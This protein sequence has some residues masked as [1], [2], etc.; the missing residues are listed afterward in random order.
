MTEKIIQDAIKDQK[1]Q[2]PECSKPLLKYENFAATVDAV[3]DGFNV[4]EID[5]SAS[6]VTLI[7]GNGDCKWKERTEYWEDFID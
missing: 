1:M 3:R 5:S 7:C 6:R 2:C 4:Q